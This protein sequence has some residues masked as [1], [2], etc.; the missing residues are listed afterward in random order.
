M[1]RR[2]F[3]QLGAGVL[4]AASVLGVGGGELSATASSVSKPRLGGQLTVGLIN[5]VNGLN[6]LASSLAT[7]GTYYG[8]AI[9]DPIAIV[10]ADGTVKPYLCQSITPNS[11]Y[12]SWTFKLRPEIKFHDGTP[13]DSAALVNQ[14]QHVLHSPF[15]AVSAF[16][17]VTA[18][19]PVDSLT[20]RLDLS[21]P[22]VAL[23]AYLTGT[24]GTG[25][26]GFVAAPSMLANPNGAMQPVGTGPFIF[27]SWEPGSHLIVKRNPN[28]WQKGLPYLSQ[29][30]FM[31]IS[32]DTSRL[33]SLQ[34]GTVDLIQ[35]SNP[36]EIAQMLASTSINVLDNVKAPPIEPS[37]SF[38][39]LNTKQPPL[40]DVGVR[41]ALAYATDQKKV[42]AVTGAGLGT[43]ST[44]L[45]SPGSKYYAPTG[46]P[47]FDLAKAKSLV[48]QYKA[49]HGGAAPSF[50][51][52]V[53]GTTYLDMAQQ[54][55]QMWKQA[56]IDVTRITSIEQS[57]YTTQQL[58]GSYLA[59]T[60]QQY[61]AADPDQN[62]SY[63]SSTTNA[64]LGTAA[65]NFARFSNPTIQAALETGRSDPNPQARIK[66][67]QTVSDQ[68]AK[69]VPYIW[70]TRQIWAVGS[71][72]NV[73][74]VAK[75]SI[76]SGGHALP[77]SQGDVWLHQI[78]MS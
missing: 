17:T 2:S 43:P 67:Y 61:E 36:L 50:P 78:W 1:D 13:L 74:G 28:Y 38:V 25:Q 32:D 54:L 10:A 6:P 56:G 5:E 70:I 68:F 20:V 9:F 22:W 30:T 26:L 48:A 27:E 31:P 72:K 60:Q 71:A 29:I 12:T 19:T 23:P 35:M 55:Q 15:S 44:G 66:A 41:R 33:Q 8:R 45:F 75:V 7:S 57:T 52:G 51:L 76:P 3:L 34:A 63:W 16:A 40:D 21:S 62:F 53:A 42:I 64:P 65:I 24:V 73:N 58:T 18:I 49:S 77:L 39:M 37:Q 4:G 47:Q 11:A 46:Y 69:Y 14:F 59:D